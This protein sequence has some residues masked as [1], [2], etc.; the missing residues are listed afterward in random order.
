VTPEEAANN[1]TV[2]ADFAGTTTY[3]ASSTS[4]PFTV[5]SEDDTIGFAARRSLPT[6]DRQ[7]C[8]PPSRTRPVPPRPRQP[9]RSRARP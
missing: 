7:P 9:V 8:Q 6:A 3:L 1:Y 2:T 4:S 5:R